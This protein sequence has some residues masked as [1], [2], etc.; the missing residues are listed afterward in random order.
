MVTQ[1]GMSDKLGNVDLRSNFQNL[2]PETKATIESEVRNLIEDGRLRAKK[3]LIEKRVELDRLA[4]ALMDYE[5]LDGE[6]A[7]KVIRGEALKNRE[8]MPN[9]GIKRPSGPPEN[10]NGGIEVPA[11]P[12][13]ATA[14]AAG[15]ANPQPPPSGGVVA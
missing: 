4:K 14:A 9:G 6:E 8:L 5:T 7:H 10:G 1:F 2:S 13:S 3:L 15:A 11:I 12:G